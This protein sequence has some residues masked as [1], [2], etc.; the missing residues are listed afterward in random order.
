MG[1]TS[2]GYTG[3]TNMNRNFGEYD[4]A[5]YAWAIDFVRCIEEMSTLR[6]LL[7]RLVIGKY[8][9]REYVGLR[10]RLDY[11]DRTDSSQFGYGL[12]SCNY[13]KEPWKWIKK[14]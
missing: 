10:E 2:F 13:H 1:I 4:Y 7:I 11:T 8:A 14:T 6:K 12:E 3:K 9:A 5:L